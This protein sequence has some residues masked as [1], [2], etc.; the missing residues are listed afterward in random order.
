MESAAMVWEPQIVPS[1]L[2]PEQASLSTVIVAMQAA[3]DRSAIS[4]ALESGGWGITF[5]TDGWELLDLLGGALVSANSRARPTLVL[6]DPELAGPLRSV[7]LARIQRYFPGLPV[8][9]VLPE[10]ERWCWGS[11]VIGVLRGPF[12]A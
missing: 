5:A 11:G 7:V 3:S 10:G 2:F 1:R 9:L 8:L 6:L 12:L 4:R